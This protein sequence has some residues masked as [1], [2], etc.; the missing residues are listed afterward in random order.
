MQTRAVV[1]QRCN[2]GRCSLLPSS[3]ALSLFRAYYFMAMYEERSRDV[4]V[5][6]TAATAAL[7]LSIFV[8]V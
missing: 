4:F 5:T 3:F 7:A 2:P 1:V 6:L 8:C